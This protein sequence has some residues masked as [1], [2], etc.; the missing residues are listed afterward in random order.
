M[1][2][3]V[4]VTVAASD[5]NLTTVAKV[6]DRLGITVATFD[7]KIGLM[8]AEASAFCAH[9][10]DRVFARETVSEAF[11]LADDVDALILSRYPVVSI[12]STT[13]NGEVLAAEYYELDKEKGLL[14]RLSG[15][16]RICWPDARLST[17]LYVAGYTLPTDVPKDL[18]EACIELV[19]S[20]YSASTRDPMAKRIEI[21]DVETID[22]WVGGIGEKS[23]GLPPKVKTTLDLFRAHTC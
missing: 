1:N 16:S 7:T 20:A 6:K 19:K 8:I 15:S 4:T 2:S 18:E 23:F 9:Y 12:T 11:R 10:C 3:I 14:Y 13:V 22:Y 5:F 21:P 17:I